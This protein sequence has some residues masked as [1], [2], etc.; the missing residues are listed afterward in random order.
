MR[1]SIFSISFLWLLL[2]GLLN[3]FSSGRWS[4]VAAGWLSPIFGLYFLHNYQG[5]RRF[6]MFYLVLWITLS[7]AWWGGTPI[8]GAAH[9]VFM[10]VN[11]L[12]GSLPFILDRWLLTR[13]AEAG[14][15]PFYSTLIFPL[16][17]TAIEYL[18]SS[19]NPIGNFGAAGY[20]QYGF[21]SLLQIT[22]VTG[23]LGLTFL[24]NWFASTV[25]WVWEHGFAWDRVRKGVIVY[26]VIML[27]V[28]GYGFI[29]LRTAPSTAA[30]EVTIASFTLHDTN[31]QKWNE[32]VR[33][34]R[35]TFRQ[36]TQAVHAAYL[37]R[38]AVAEADIVLWPEAAIVGVA[39]D[40]T[41]AIMQGQALAR[42]KGI[43]LAMPTVTMFPDSDRPGENIL[44]L[45]DPAGEIV[46]T[47]VKFGGNLFEGTLAGSGELQVVDT[48]YGR[49]S[50][51]ICWDTDF[52]GV[53]RQAGQQ[54]V[55]ILLSPS[56]DWEGINPM[57]GEMSAFRALENGL[58]VVRQAD[59][60]LSLVT[61]A[62]GR[63]IASSPAVE[64]ELLA[65]VASE[66]PVTPYSGLGDL[67]GLLSLVG[68]I[69][70]SG[71]V[72][73]NGR[74]AQQPRAETVSLA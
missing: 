3:L 31:M 24:I 45:A 20:S 54:H 58:T 60:G 23:M 6:L 13:I 28:L 63:N 47:H 14:E 70:L 38:T 42:E 50:A 64:A 71:A 27:L 53:I 36:E 5:K 12:I 1:K 69:V 35:A 68:L 43:Y 55:D 52:P 66:G 37:S 30:N 56:L 72:I 41:A 4:M 39:E 17:V 7:I 33:S 40:V 29:R 59:K 21:D 19:S 32:L 22:A 18:T 49:L 16:A 57:H 11:A 46:L 2:F 73:L 51:A 48:P 34:D 61:D 26:A 65:V 9:F 8:W 10:A 15:R 67:G 25:V 62:Y 44:Y 74:R